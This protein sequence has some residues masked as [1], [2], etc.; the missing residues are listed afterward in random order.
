MISFFQRSNLYILD[1][2]ILKVIVH[3]RLID[4]N[5]MYEISNQSRPTIYLLVEIQ[6]MWSR[7]GPKFQILFLYSLDF[8]VICKLKL[9]RTCSSMIWFTVAATACSFGLKVEALLPVVVVGVIEGDSAIVRVYMRWCGEVLL[10]RIVVGGSEVAVL[11]FY[12]CSARYSFCT[13][14][15]YTT[16]RQFEKDKSAIKGL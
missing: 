16:T 6:R 5:G 1:A 3:R 7:Y 13:A 12:A 15:L 8:W 9:E 10:L 4:Q 2:H 14:I 11:L